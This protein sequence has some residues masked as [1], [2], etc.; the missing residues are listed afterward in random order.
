MN[1]YVSNMIGF[2]FQLKS[3]SLTSIKNLFQQVFPDDSLF[4]EY[5]RNLPITH[6]L[7]A[8]MSQLAQTSPSSSSLNTLGIYF[9]NQCI[10][11]NSFI[12]K[13]HLALGEWLIDQIIEC[14]EPIHP[15][16]INLVNNYINQLFNLN[17]LFEF[18]LQPLI[19]SKILKFFKE[20]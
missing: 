10:K 5:S 17:I 16:M 19:H 4:S 11:T 9:L 7:N 2:R 8:K 20:K 6:K 1:E 15:V 14:A 3:N 13:R 18:R 12:N